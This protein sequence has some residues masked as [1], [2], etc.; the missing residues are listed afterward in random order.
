MVILIGSGSHHKGLVAEN[1][2]EAHV[3]DIHSAAV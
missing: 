3:R 1:M 2:E